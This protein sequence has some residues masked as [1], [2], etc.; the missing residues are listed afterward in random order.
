M[1]YLNN[2]I[3]FTELYILLNSNLKYH[4]IFSV[5]NIIEAEKT[6][7]LK[8]ICLGEP[9]FYYLYED[10]ISQEFLISYLEA[11]RR[12]T[13]APIYKYVRE[14]PTK[15]HYYSDIEIILSNYKNIEKTDQ[16]PIYLNILYRIGEHWSE[17]LF[18][19]LQNPQK[20]DKNSK[21]ILRNIDKLNSHNPQLLR[22]LQ[23]LVDIVLIKIGEHDFVSHFGIQIFY[24]Y[25]R[26]DERFIVSL[27]PDL[28]TPQNFFIFMGSPAV[29]GNPRVS[30]L[31]Q[32]FIS[33]QNNYPNDFRLLQQNNQF[34]LL[35]ESIM[36]N[37]HFADIIFSNAHNHLMMRDF[38]IVAKILDPFD[39]LRP[40][41]LLLDYEKISPD[42]QFLNDIIDYYAKPNFPMNFFGRYRN[43]DGFFKFISNTI[44]RTITAKDLLEISITKFLLPTITSLTVEDVLQYGEK[45]ILSYPDEDRIKDFTVIY[46]FKALEIILN[47]IQGQPF[48]DSLLMNLMANIPVSYHTEFIIDILS[49]LFLQDET[50]K[51]VCSAALTQQVLTVLET[52]AEE[53]ELKA[54]IAVGLNKLQRGLVMNAHSIS[55]C[56]LSTQDA[57][58][59]AFSNYEYDMAEIIS[60][61][62]PKLNS[63]CVMAHAISLLQNGHEKLIPKDW[64]TPQ[65]WINYCLST[66]KSTEKI[67]TDDK[68]ILMIV[69]KRKEDHQIFND[70]DNILMKINFSNVL[71]EAKAH[72]VGKSEPFN[73]KEFPRLKK[74]IDYVDLYNKST[75][76]DSTTSAVDGVIHSDNITDIESMEKLLGKNAI[77]LV[78]SSKE[79][80]TAS[81]SVKAIFNAISPLIIKASELSCKKND[82]SEII[83][84]YKYV[85]IQREF[86]EVFKT[87]SN[88]IN[89]F[90]MTF[91]ATLQTLKSIT[92]S[93]LFSALDFLDDLFLFDVPQEHIE[94]LLSISL[95]Y[96]ETISSNFLQELRI[97]WPQI[98]DKYKDE[99]KRKIQLSDY[100]I[101]FPED[102]NISLEKVLNSGI[103]I[104]DFATA[105]KQLVKEDKDN[106]ALDFAI[107]NH[108]EDEFVNIMKEKIVSKLN[109]NQTFSVHF[110]NEEISHK[111]FH[112]LPEEHR[113]L[114]NQLIIT[115][116]GA[117]AKSLLSICDEFPDIECDIELFDDFVKNAKD[118]KSIKSLYGRYTKNMKNK[119]AINNYTYKLIDKTINDV[120]VDSFESEQKAISN[121]SI[122]ESILS[123]YDIVSDL[124][125][126]KILYFNKLVNARLFDRFSVAYSFRGFPDHT[127]NIRNILMKYDEIGLIYDHKEL[128]DDDIALPLLNQCLNC[129]NL[130]FFTEGMK[131]LENATFPEEDTEDIEKLVNDGIR[132]L[133]H[134]IPFEL[135]YLSNPINVEIVPPCYKISVIIMGRGGA[136][137]GQDQFKALAKLIET[138]AGLNQVLSFHVTIGQFKELF[139]VWKRLPPLLQSVQC[140]IERIVKPALYSQ[141]VQQ[142]WQ[143][144]AKNDGDRESFKPLDDILNFLRSH[145]M[146][147][148]LA[149]A[150]L[151]LGNFEDAIISLLET[152]NDSGS[153][154]ELLARLDIL[155]TAVSKEKAVRSGRQ[156]V[157][158]I[159]PARLSKIEQ[160]TRLQRQYIDMC[161]N[162]KIRFN[163]HHDILTNDGGAQQMALI[164]LF[165]QEFTLAVQIADSQN[166]LKEVVE[167]LVDKVEYAGIEVIKDILAKMSD[168]MD[169]DNYA[170]LSTVIMTTLIPKLKKTNVPQFIVNN[171]KGAELQIGLLANFNYLT[172][173]MTIARKYGKREGFIIV[174]SAATAV[175]N[176]K[177]ASE[178]E[179][180]S[181]K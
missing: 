38:Q 74:F 10:T 88:D 144:L 135:R 81:D 159:P 5:P 100:L 95:R 90:I 82:Y 43:E 147:I 138:F 92:E 40:Y 9:C 114:V 26:I 60:Q 51:F 11:L 113:T 21:N 78:L 101:I 177:L 178:C 141:Q 57:V 158:K 152:E 62:D 146:M 116:N 133:K 76:S 108:M 145:R 132:T 109:D 119:E 31:Y 71:E 70:Y 179:K 129:C 18:D 32:R 39:D 160:L 126:K 80:S 118:L 23:S 170:K 55:E 94:K 136:L 61:N 167:Q 89:M 150:Q 103:E 174:E 83:L 134:A 112:S 153:W 154:K 50:G 99:I 37:K 25:G 155:Q 64:F 49:L 122:I 87:S 48:D 120:Y 162:G 77:E 151:K 42:Q 13:P 131:F 125:K 63:I 36:K 33:A 180:L 4:W 139:D 107:N 163:K 52:F 148:S 168:K 53:K 27:P 16:T 19:I 98:V 34:T 127:E 68:N 24:I 115:H 59:V 75:Q 123:S 110:S 28:I 164:C 142:L 65:L 91:L 47:S 169:L 7:I 121:L 46:A 72:F 130:G 2:P 96:C 1:I 176:H 86:D 29:I 143:Y 175:G 35:N 66:G 117:K 85:F 106:V 56:L 84:K 17:N 157:C 22:A 15:S 124:L 102:S 67:T 45:E 3:K 140:A 137:I 73:Y 58:M 165:N 128:W 149:D 161:I 93:I 6:E 172:E 111:I 105:I 69:N 30:Q 171:I 97:R 166:C 44:G 8:Q 181:R 41:A 20:I 54:R 104:R 173:A 156:A 14:S 79:I 12:L